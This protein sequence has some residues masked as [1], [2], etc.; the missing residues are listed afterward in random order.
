MNG[1]LTFMIKRSE[2]L[3]VGG[4][5]AVDAGYVGDYVHQVRTELVCLAVHWVGVRGEIQLGGYVN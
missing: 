3:R 4:G 2:G 1:R 5:D